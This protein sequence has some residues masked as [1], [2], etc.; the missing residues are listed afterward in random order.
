MVEDVLMAVGNE[1]GHGNIASVSR[2]N[3]VIVVFLKE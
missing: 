1:V 3:K 2:M